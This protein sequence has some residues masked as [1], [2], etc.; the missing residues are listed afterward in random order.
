MQSASNTKAVNVRNVI[1]KRELNAYFTS[2]VAYIVCVL[3]L[4]FSGF[5][6][7]STFF[8]AGRAELR[9]FFNMLPIMFS[10]F[11]PA[12]TMRLFSEEQRVGSME[13]LLTLPVTVTDIVLGKY[14][15]ALI[16]SVVLLVPSLS[17]VIVCYMFGTPDV[18]PIIGSYAGAILLA[19][20]FTAIGIFASSCTKN[21]I[22]AF[23]IAFALCIFLTLISS[24]AVIM[25]AQIAAIISFIS[26][27]S[28]FD[29]ISRGIIDTRDVLYFISLIAIFL[30]LTINTINNS[31]KG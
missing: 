12:L 14:R 1:M 6:F 26:A 2:P 8:I 15:A 17:Y 11:I 31:R 27:D 10:F 25:P 3:F 28:H 24:F 4:L 30:V 18:G 21:Q 23:F 13:T 19:A 20:A 7:F 9:A 29:S 5:T 22:V 16:S